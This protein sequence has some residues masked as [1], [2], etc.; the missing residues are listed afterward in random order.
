MQKVGVTTN[1]PHSVPFL[2]PSDEA[3]SC[4]WNYW[5]NSLFHNQ[6]FTEFLHLPSLHDLSIQQSVGIQVATDGK[7]HIYMNGKYMACVAAEL[8]IEKPLWG[9]VDVYAIP[10]KIKS[11]ILS[12]EIDTLRHADVVTGQSL[13]NF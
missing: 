4:E 9:A 7:M 12:G 11:E 6:S 1:L 2:L 3:G 8:P 5:G 10:T 13:L